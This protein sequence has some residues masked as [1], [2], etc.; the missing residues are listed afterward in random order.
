M[1][2]TDRE[3]FDVQL[4]LLCQGYGFWVGDRSEAYWKGLSK[5]SLSSFMR[6]VEFAIGED[7]P[8]KLPNTHAIWKIHHG[9]R[10][11][12]PE[13]AAAVEPIPPAQSKWLMRVNSLFLK[14]LK[15]RRL[16]ENFKG[17]IN[18]PLRRA[19][20]LELVKWFEGLEAEREPEATAE[21]MAKRFGPMMA[22]I[23]DG[24]SEAA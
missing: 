1:Y 22:R 12:S 5:M 20:C 11:K 6:C 13:Q 19:K 14:Y 7:G 9:L 10:A 18:L 15:Q 3:Q 17:D 4:S 2:S 8:E 21:E 24:E 23:P 16:I